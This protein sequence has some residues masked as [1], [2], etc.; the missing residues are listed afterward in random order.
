MTLTFPHPVLTPITGKPDHSNIKGLKKQ[1]Y[2]NAR[3]IH[4]TR[5]GGTLG[6]LGCIM[7]S[8]EY[9][10]RA[11]VAY[12]IPPFPG[13]NPV[14]VDKATQAQITE[15]NRKHDQDM[16]A[17]HLH[18]AVVKSL[19]QQIIAA[20]HNRYTKA[21]EDSEMGYSDVTCAQMLAHLEKTYGQLTDDHLEQNRNTLSEAWNVDDPIEDL[22]SRIGEA[23]RISNEAGIGEAINDAT[24]IRLTL[25]VFERTGV[26]DTVVE[27]WRDKGPRMTFSNFKLHFEAGLKERERKITAQTAGYHGANAITR[28]VEER[29]AAAMT[30]DPPGTIRVD[31]INMYYCW[32]H[33]LGMTRTHTSLLCNRKGENHQDTAT[34]NNM[35]GGNNRI[36]GPRSGATRGAHA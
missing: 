29:A 9:V 19:K 25:A 31:N 27:K 3:Q 12:T 20:V 14:E 17:F 5:G 18:N 34:A 22:W 1:L 21:L 15:G 6:H 30:Q 28:P 11:G 4:S 35:M 16:A 32:T 36:M 33:G 8:A 26:I 7:E 10:A 2:S 23:Q 24:V 13:A